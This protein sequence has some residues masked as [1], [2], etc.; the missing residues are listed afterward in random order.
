MCFSIYPRL[1]YGSKRAPKKYRRRLNTS[2][3]A[4]EDLSRIVEA[5]CYPDNLIKM[6]QTTFNTSDFSGKSPEKH[7]TNENITTPL[8]SF[9]YRQAPAGIALLRMNTLQDMPTKLAPGPYS[10]T[11]LTPNALGAEMYIT[12]QPNGYYIADHTLKQ[13]WWLQSVNMERLFKSD[14]LRHYPPTTFVPQ[15]ID[16]NPIG[17]DNLSS[18]ISTAP[19]SPTEAKMYLDLLKELQVHSRIIYR[20]GSPTAI[21]D[22]T[23]T[24]QVPSITIF[25]HIIGIFSFYVSLTYLKRL[26]T[27]R[28]GGVT[29]FVRWKAMVESLLAEWSDSNLLVGSIV[30]G[31]HHVR[32]HRETKDISA[33]EAAAYFRRS[34][35]SRRSF[36]TLSFFLSM[37]L[38]FLSWS[39]VAFLCGVSMY[40][41]Q[42]MR[43]FSTYIIEGVVFGL[44][45]VCLFSMVLHFYWVFTVEKKGKKSLESV[46]SDV[47]AAT[48]LDHQP[49]VPIVEQHAPVYNSVRPEIAD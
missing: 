28:A 39:L 2:V 38:I 4:I 21:I 47:N 8:H 9:R 34:G 49:A 44:I 45:C 12:L 36:R 46:A 35:G 19:W 42:S 27:T 30:S 3:L 31:L 26:H 10:F 41:F 14:D 43:P 13:I 20:H 22:Y 32:V 15:F 29:S 6:M 25:D 23:H 24:I 17:V 11:K 7:I 33:A 1:C 37:P 48:I 16:L 5:A 18:R 40:A